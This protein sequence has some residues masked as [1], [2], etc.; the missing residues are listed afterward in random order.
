MKRIVHVH[1]ANEQHRQEFCP[2]NP[3]IQEIKGGFKF[4]HNAY[5]GRDVLDDVILGVN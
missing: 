5:D 3:V 1:P 2:C 4:I